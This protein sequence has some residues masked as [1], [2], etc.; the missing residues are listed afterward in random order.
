MTV[1]EQGCKLDVAWDVVNE[2]IDSMTKTVVFF[3]A[4]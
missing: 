3:T 2:T 1:V 4:D